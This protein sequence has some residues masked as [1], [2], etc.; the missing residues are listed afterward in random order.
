MYDEEARRPEPV[1]FFHACWSTMR[2]VTGILQ[3]GATKMEFS[4][5]NLPY[6][7]Y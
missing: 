4:K 1:L 5:G 2:P 7:T 3:P 6:V